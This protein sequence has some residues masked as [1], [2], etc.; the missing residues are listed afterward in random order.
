MPSEDTAQ[1]ARCA[2]SEQAFWCSKLGSPFTALICS[3][4]AE[5]LDTSTGV[6]R[7]LLSWPGDP[8]SHA[9]AVPLRVCG[10]LHRL[11]RSGQDPDLASLYPGA[12]RQVTD[13]VK[14]E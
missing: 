4:F 11:A 9:D 14:D 10:A 2:F 3:A 12:G 7:Q 8:S 13:V 5:R 6:G 1:R